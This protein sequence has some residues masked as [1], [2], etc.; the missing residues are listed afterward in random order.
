LKAFENEEVVL[1]CA[2]FLTDVLQAY[3][4]LSFVMI[5]SRRV[6]IKQ[7]SV[8]VGMNLFT[9]EA[10]FL[11]EN[12]HHIGVERVTNFRFLWGGIVGI[13]VAILFWAYSAVLWIYAVL[14]V[15]FFLAGAFA[16]YWFFIFYNS[17]SVV[18]DFSK[19]DLVGSWI[20]SKGKS[21]FITKRLILSVGQCFDVMYAIYDQAKNV[22]AENNA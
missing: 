5:T 18:I 17:N 8:L 11:Y 14:G 19:Q 15:I 1:R 22:Y 4:L 13:L 10:S 6:V 21:A 2:G 12:L 3:T 20:V 7:R 9:V 16:I